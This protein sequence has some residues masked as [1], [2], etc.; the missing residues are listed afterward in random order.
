MIAAGRGVGERPIIR[1][2][3]KPMD[4]SSGIDQATLPF[5]ALLGIEFV[6]ATADRI[7]ARMTSARRIFAHAPQYCT[8]VP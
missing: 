7:V 3:G 6:S 1:H 5:A 4:I 8:A 2:K